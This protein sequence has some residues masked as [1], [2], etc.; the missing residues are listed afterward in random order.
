MPTID[1]HF[2]LH[3]NQ[4]HDESVKEMHAKTAASA[5]PHRTIMQ[6]MIVTAVAYEGVCSTVRAVAATA[7]A[8]YVPHTLAEYETLID[9]NAHA[10]HLAA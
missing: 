6:A 7:R 2:A 8:V 10:V 3:P 9:R 4:T 5:H 1:I